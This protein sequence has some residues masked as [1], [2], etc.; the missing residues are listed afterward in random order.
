MLTAS[1]DSQ[2][3]LPVPQPFLGGKI[4]FPASTAISLTDGHRTVILMCHTCTLLHCQILICLCAKKVNSRVMQIA[5]L[6]HRCSTHTSLIAQIIL[7]QNMSCGTKPSRIT[8]L[9]NLL[10]VAFFKTLCHCF[11]VIMTDFCR[12]FPIEKQIGQLFLWIVPSF[13]NK[14]LC[15]SNAPRNPGPALMEHA[16]EIAAVRLIGEKALHLI[17]KRTAKNFFIML[18]CQLQKC[19]YTLWIQIIRR[20]QAVIP[21]ALTRNLLAQKQ[22]LFINTASSSSFLISRT[23]F[24]PLNKSAVRRRLNHINTLKK[25]CLHSFFH[26]QI[27]TAVPARHG[28]FA[29]ASILATH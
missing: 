5:K 17:W 12:P 29:C 25:L 2:R 21:L 22:N 1:G 24:H 18:V 20:H 6:R 28:I 7:I 23:F 26:C 10:H 15:K 3:K 4:Q 19:L 8:P 13:F 11:P 27:F 14:I 9:I 16:E